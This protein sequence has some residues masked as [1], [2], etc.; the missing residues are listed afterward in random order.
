M[1]HVYYLDDAKEL[2]RQGVDGFGHIVRDKPVDKELLD[3]MKAKGTWQVVL[4]PQPRDRLQPW[5]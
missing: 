1:A 3:M 4:D 5:R 2:V